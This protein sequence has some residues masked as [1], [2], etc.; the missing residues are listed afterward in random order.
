MDSGISKIFFQTSKAP[1]DPSVSEMIKYRLTDDWIYK[2]YLDADILQFFV[3]HPDPE[4]PNITEFFQ[5]LKRGE[6]KA[7]LFRYYHIY[8][9]GGFFMDSDAM[10]YEPIKRIVQNYTF[11]SVTCPMI[12]GLFQG[13]LGAEPKNPVIYQAL[14]SF[15]EMDLTILDT[16]YHYLCKDINN[17]YNSYQGDKT[18]YRLYLETGHGKRMIDETDSTL[19]FKHFWDDKENIPN[20]LD[21]Q[22]PYDLFIK[23]I[24]EKNKNIV[25]PR[26]LVYFCV[27]YNHNYF[28]LLELLLKTM[29]FF[30]TTDTF[31]I[32]V[33]TNKDYESVVQ[34]LS[35]DLGIPL[36]IMC[37]DFTTIFQAA[38]AR[39]YIF[40]YEDIDSYDKILYLDTDIIIKKDIAPVFNIDAGDILYGIESGTISSPSFGNQFFDFSQIDGSTPGINSGTLLFKNC[41]AMRDLFSRIQE[42]INRHTTHGLPIPY[43][44]DQPFI[45]YHVI[46]DVMYDNKYMNQ[47]V[48]LYEDEDNVENY[49]TSSIC[50]FSYPIGNFAHKYE[51]MQKFVIKILHEELPDQ[52]IPGIIGR[53]YT[54][55]SG[56]IKFTLDG[57]DTTW[58]PGKYDILHADNNVVRVFWNN[59]FHIL[60]MNDALDSYICIRVWP[61]DF[62]LIKGLEIKNDTMLYIYGDSHAY[63]SFNHLKIRHMQLFQY[64]ITMHRIARD[65]K[66]INFHASH[67]GSNSI[68]CLVYGEVDVRC[69]IGK[70]CNLGRDELDICKSLVSG[71]FNTVRSQITLYKAIIIVGISPPA[72]PID[73][74]HEN[75]HPDGPL[76]F[77]GTNEDRV[78]YTKIMNNLIEEECKKANYI[79]FNPYKYYTRDDG[80]LKYELSDN[81]IHLGKNDYFLEEFTRLYKSL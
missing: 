10:I 65:N 81:C 31:D 49:E 12:N 13:I 21:S 3:D 35:V 22:K 38:C 76:P 25:K 46:K 67:L 28:K 24:L 75:A 71:Y 80:C 55:E 15:Y 42:H 78:K 56:Y 14:K 19:L 40:N 8:K 51:R 59:H 4:F 52:K 23:K 66:I 26:N 34:K 48:S 33:V 74:V 20:T 79:Y 32:L 73:H 54:W 37:I 9:I 17:I 57:L 47:H 53:S 29:Q 1:L 6:H 68:F 69:H 77:I 41:Q 60:K 2:H 27:F 61:R 62:G 7:D 50:H 11:V 16:D 44:M 39:L 5:S 70:Q 36:K 45:N 63:L 43:C 64:S 72:D 18:R 58:G 30:S